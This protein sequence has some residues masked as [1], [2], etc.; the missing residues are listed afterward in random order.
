[1]IRKIL[2]AS[3]SVLVLIQNLS[4]NHAQ[5]KST[6]LST[7]VLQLSTNLGCEILNID[8]VSDSTNSTNTLQFTKGAFAAVELMPGNYQFGSL[9]CSSNG[10]EDVVFHEVFAQLPSL[11]LKEG[12]I[13]YGGRLILKDVTQETQASALK[14]CTVNISRVRGA[15]NNECL[16]S[17]ADESRLK[18]RRLNVYVPVLDKE[19]INTV[20]KALAGNSQDLIYLPLVATEG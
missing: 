12:E 3:V 4:L 9:T 16:T 14:D 15:D 13:Y 6:S 1:M 8:L 10:R 20:A 19:D 18:K 7:Y 5:A 17:G 11:S 2:V